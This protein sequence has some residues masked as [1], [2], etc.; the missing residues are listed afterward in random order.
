MSTTRW[1]D[2]FLDKMRQTRDEKA[3]TL[4]EAM[5]KK[6]HDAEDG[7]RLFRALITNRDPVPEHAPQ[8]IKDYFNVADALPAWADMELIRKGTELFNLHGP[9]F[10]LALFCKA[11][12]ECYAGKKGAQVLYSTGRLNQQRGQEK[13]FQR[14][15]AET[16]QFTID[17]M[18]EGGLTRADGQ[19][20]R[21]IQKV[22][23][24][25]AAIRHYITVKP[26]WHSVERDKLGQPPLP[27]D[28]GKSGEPI[29]Q[30]DLV[31][32][33]LAFSSVTL[34]GAIA[35]GLPL[36]MEEQEA[37]Y[38]T[39]RVIGHI[40]GIREEVLP[41]NVGEARELWERIDQRQFRAS[42]E[43]KALARS[44]V[45]FLKYILGSWW[46][47]GLPEA[48][49]FLLM[50]SRVAGYLG[51]RGHWHYRLA[52]LMMNDVL[53]IILPFTHLIKSRLS[54][55]N[56]VMRK[57][58]H[59][60]MQKLITSWND[61]KQVQFVIPPGLRDSWKLDAPEPQSGPK[62]EKPGLT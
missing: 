13:A 26:G 42:Y 22:R 15:I 36:K 2:E 19:A 14:R 60:F 45:D 46:I 28:A 24:I 48:V 62:P 54:M 18:A 43:G 47:S 34:D 29:N 5:M 33:L 25:H 12:P 55:L 58:S 57:L 51:V 39:W 6:G 9:M 37:Y 7:A 35:M 4:L 61:E 20:I 16:A 10:V 52:V 53:G 56:W 59:R 49:M 44:L 30:E 8:E 50:G 21:T 27:W 1:T 41:V 31:G 38:H 40:L 3:D 11:L 32:T 23:L 17:V